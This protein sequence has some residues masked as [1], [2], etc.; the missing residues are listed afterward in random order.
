MERLQKVIAHAGVA[1]RRKAE[2]LIV[3]GKVKV[4]GE[5]VTEL[6][7]K[8]SK[9]QY[10]EVNGK[11][12]QKEDKVYYV[13]NKP[14]KYICSNNDEHG[15]NTVGSLIECQYRIYP[16]GRL[17]YDSSGVLLMTNDGDFTNLMI[18]P[19]YHISKTYSVII[20]GIMKIED[21]KKLEQGVMLDDVMTL[22]CKIKI[23]NKDVTKG[24]TFFDITIQEGRNRQIRRMM[25][26]FG[27]EVTLLHRK[28]FGVI[29]DKGL[30]MGEYRRLKPFEIKQLRTMAESGK[31]I[32]D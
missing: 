12:I 24:Q 1:S 15:R 2:E 17:D 6:G 23:R 11:A 4:D 10:I 8:V 32:V 28:Q 29:T 30:K 21:L 16:V 3:Q 22:P 31:L 20:K 27:Y 25:E 7:Y 18:H 5:V 26:M 9:H 19:R 13:V 14:K